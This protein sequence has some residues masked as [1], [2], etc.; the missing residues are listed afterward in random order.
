VGQPYLHGC[1]ADRPPL[2]YSYRHPASHLHPHLHARGMADCYAH[3]YSHSHAAADA[4]M[5]TTAH[6]HAVA[7]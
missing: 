4:Y 2:G 1:R 3:T 7:N 6:S 5:D